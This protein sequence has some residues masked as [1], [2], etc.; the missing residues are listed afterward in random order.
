MHC[1]GEQREQSNDDLWVFWR[2]LERELLLPEMGKRGKEAGLWGRS[3]S[4]LDLNRLRLTSLFN[5]HVIRLQS[6][7]DI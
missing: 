5:I 7:L 4:V 6:Q 3:R 2:E 1:V